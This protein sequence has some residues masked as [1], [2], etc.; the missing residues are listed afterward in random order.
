MSDEAGTRPGAVEQRTLE[1]VERSSSGAGSSP[2][3]ALV[4]RILSGDEAAFEM[5]YERYLPRVAGFIRKR[6]DNPADMEEAVQDTFI[7]VFSSLASFRGESPF[8][9]WVLGI[10]RRTV[11][12][13]FKRKQHPTVPLGVEEPD[14]A[15]PWDP[16]IEPL[17]SPHD[18]YE[19]HERLLRLE[20]VA[21]RRLSGEQQR[22]FRL[23]HLEH[24]SITDIAASLQ[25]SEDAIKSNLYRA[26]K[27]LLSG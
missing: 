13:R 7:A 11:A 26:R 25:K 23:H 12:N 9:A 5:L 8:A 22:L 4:Q 1:Q 20:D 17:A 18:L 2:E 3:A 10:A 15:D 27:L 19:C 6:L 14:S 16:M 24:Q 21:R